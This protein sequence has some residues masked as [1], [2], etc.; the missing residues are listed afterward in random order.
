MMNREIVV[1]SLV[2]LTALAVLSGAAPARAQAFDL[3]VTPAK[4]EI[5]VQA[6]Q[7][8]D[9]TITLINQAPEQLE[10]M[11][12]PMDYSVNPDNTFFFEEPGYYTYSCA[13]WLKIDRQRVIIPPN[14]Q[15]SEQFSISVPPDAEPGGHYGVIFF[16][17]VREPPP[18]QGATPAPRI[19]SLI[20]LT[21]PGDILREG[22]ITAFE[23]GS[24]Y[25]SLWAPPEGE[26][27]KWPSRGIKYHL[28]IQN[29]G[30]VHITTYAEIRYW[31]RFGFG[32][33][34]VELGLMTILPGTVRYYD[35]YLPGPPALGIFKAEA[36]MQ[37]GPDQ[38]TFDVERRA[39][40]GFKVI[41]VIWIVLIV[42]GAA[43][44]IWGMSRLFRRLKGKKL[45]ISI[46][47]EGKKKGDNG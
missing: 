11:V 1:A 13:K 26:P 41:P 44:L 21:V 23:I 20:L 22:S 5:T 42:L 40:A 47:V 46:R 32:S 27:A 39:E 30:N 18:G 43:A 7:S 31:P 16:Q 37:Y 36:I 25:F 24:D 6:G 38:A 28:E 15:L 4:V 45:R 17:D 8:A 34:T 9:F 14:S 2:V 33:G 3:T 35:G 29:T 19:G 12:Y 10:L